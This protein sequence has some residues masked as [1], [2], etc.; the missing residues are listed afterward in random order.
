MS[1]HTQAP[2]RRLSPMGEPRNRATR[3]AECLAETWNHAAIC[4]DCQDRHEQPEYP[5]CA[6]CGDHEP[7]NPDADICK[8]CE[9]D[10]REYLADRRR[11]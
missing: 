5:L 11:R 1:D 3:C 4:D 7:H 2:H 10:E 9:V 8:G 6:R